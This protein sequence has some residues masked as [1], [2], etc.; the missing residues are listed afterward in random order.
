MR[1]A[2]A[3]CRLTTYIAHERSGTAYERRNTGSELYRS[4]FLH[5]WL[6]CTEDASRINN[7]QNK[8]QTQ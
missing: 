7:K 2:V 5:G 1:E 8:Q 3:L 4:P 6:P